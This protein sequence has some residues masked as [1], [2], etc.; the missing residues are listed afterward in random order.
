MDNLQYYN[1]IDQIRKISLEYKQ[2]ISETNNIV[3]SEIRQYNII[4]L[5][6]K[7]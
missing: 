6:L 3:Y 5:K 7:S 1:L 4:Q 2:I